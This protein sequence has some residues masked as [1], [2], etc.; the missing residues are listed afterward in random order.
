MKAALLVC[1]ACFARCAT[2]NP[3]RVPVEVKVPVLMPCKTPDVPKPEF[4]V[5]SLQTGAG[6]WAQ[7]AALRADRLQRMAYEGELNAA[8]EGCR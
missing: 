4:A 2:Q 1:V 6:I 8:V 7:M 5:D 3:V